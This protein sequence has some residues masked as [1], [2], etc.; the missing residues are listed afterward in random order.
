MDQS[1]SISTS[2]L[3]LAEAY[4]L[5]S[6]WKPVLL[7]IPFVPWAWIAAK[8]LDKHAARFFLDREKWNIAHLCC[9][10]FALLA[11]VAIP[12]R[13]EGAFWIGFAVLLLILVLDIVVFALVTN[14]DERVPE[15]FHLTLDFSKW[16]EAR[17][18]KAVAKKQGKVEL[19]IKSPD[20]SV[21]APP[22]A[23][24]PE[25]D[26]RL[27]AEQVIIKA[28]AARSSETSIVPTGKDNTYVVS[29]LV[30]GVRQNSETM[31]AADAVK[32]MNFWK[33]AAK[34]DVA[35]QRKRQNAD[36]NVERGETRRKLRM[37]S[38]GSQAGPR[39]SFLFDPEAQVKRKVE[40]MGLLEPQLTELKAIVEGG[41]GLV[42][43][44]GAP[45]NGRTTTMYTIV[46]MHDAYTKNVQTVE[47]EI[48]DSLEGVRQTKWD[49]QAEGPDLSTL[50]RTIIRRDP[51]VIAVADVPDATTAKEIA[52]AEADRTRAYAMLKTDSALGAVQA[53][54]KLVGEPDSATKGLH[55]VIAQKLVRKLC[56]NCRVAYQPTPEMV[57]KLGLP[58]D[59]V[60]Q[61][62][63]KGG[64]VL[65]KNK[66]EV[67]PVCSGIGY[68]GQ[69]GVFEVYSIGD[70][71]RGFVKNGDLTALKN[72]WRK[73]G[74]PSIQQAALRKALDGVTSVEEVMRVTAEQA[75]PKG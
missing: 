41:H 21:M 69:E 30:D 5:V 63:K 60:K 48:Q 26:V 70:A 34:M 66:P 39:L 45:D 61:L 16:T 31:P 24:T 33:A 64:Q 29:H 57:K 8:V 10:L 42:L 7:L 65:I 73:K 50:V 37:T 13:G 59:K 32:L 6:L 67:C 1:P 18:A 11:V 28:I 9:G 25:F 44:A 12:L 47:M 3:F 17:A 75:A 54:L 56:T 52:R 43:L 53:W 4:T 58:P 51:D 55:G 74:L 15:A 38:V 2:F 27:A 22:V 19:V 49:P 35:D 62:F 68:V 71:E 14:R 20:K 36:V 40:A 23:G 46:K 72:E